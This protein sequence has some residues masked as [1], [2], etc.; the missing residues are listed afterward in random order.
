MKD[1]NQRILI[2]HKMI[3][4][5]KA[6]NLENRLLALAPNKTTKHLT[7]KTLLIKRTEAMSIQWKTS[8]LVLIQRTM[9]IR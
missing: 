6:K 3:Q 2:I 8:K 1:K 9:K 4:I 5:T 7:N